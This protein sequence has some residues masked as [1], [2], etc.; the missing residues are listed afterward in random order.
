MPYP[1]TVPQ[2]TEELRHYIDIINAQTNKP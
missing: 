1:E 2:R